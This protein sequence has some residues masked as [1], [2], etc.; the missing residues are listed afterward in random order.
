MAFTSTDLDNL[1]RA[2]K[3]G[4]LTVEIDGS[5]IQY[6][7]MDELMKARAFIAEQVA[8]SSSIEIKQTVAS[9]R[10]D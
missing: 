4:A 3:N 10:R 7:S 9:Y 5:R 6:R 8:I 2:I 1:D